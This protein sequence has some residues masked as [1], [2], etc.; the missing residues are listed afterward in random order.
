MYVHMNFFETFTLKGLLIFA[1]FAS[2]LSDF[3][4]QHPTQIQHKYFM[5]KAMSLFFS[6]YFTYNL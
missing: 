4:S 6:F 1:V 2:F 3:L 5:V